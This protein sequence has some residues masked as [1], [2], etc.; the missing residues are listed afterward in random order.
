[1][2]QDIARACTGSD[3]M[4]VHNL[5]ER[6]EHSVK[7]LKK[8]IIYFYKHEYFIKVNICISYASK[9]GCVG[10]ILFLHR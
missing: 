4:F 6:N 7:Y 8:R 2:L 10:A 9:P 5:R 1:M 3:C